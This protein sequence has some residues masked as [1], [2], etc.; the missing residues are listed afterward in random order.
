LARAFRDCQA[1]PPIRAIAGEKVD[2]LDRQVELGLAAVLKLEAVVRRAL[3][4]EGAKSLVSAD[5][6]VNVDHQIAGGQGGGLR[7]EV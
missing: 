5:A 7:E 2:V 1:A 6:V 3:D 4:V